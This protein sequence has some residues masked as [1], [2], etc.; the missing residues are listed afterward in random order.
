MMMSGKAMPPSGLTARRSDAGNAVRTEA[1]LVEEV[2]RAT[3]AKRRGLDD[4]Q[5]QHREESQ[6]LSHGYLC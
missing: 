6:L 4:D 2:T 3:G 1:R 5:G